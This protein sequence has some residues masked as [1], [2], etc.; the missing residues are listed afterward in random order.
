MIELVAAFAVWRLTYLIHDEDGPWNIARN[1][2]AIFI[3]YKND[4]KWATEKPKNMIGEMISCFYCLSVWTSIPVMLYLSWLTDWRY[5]P[6]YWLGLSGAAILIE[7][8]RRH[9]AEI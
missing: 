6:L 1:F 8:A 2:R 3:E 9:L 4:G 7:I 5:A